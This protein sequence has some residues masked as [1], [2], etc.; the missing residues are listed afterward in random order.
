[1]DFNLT[2]GF[3]RV[4]KAKTLLKDFQTTFKNLQEI[5]MKIFLYRGTVQL[6]YTQVKIFS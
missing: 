4:Q 6:V 2:D 5:M 1:M 3:S